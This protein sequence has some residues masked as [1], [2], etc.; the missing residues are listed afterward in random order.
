VRN[1]DGTLETV[2]LRFLEGV[3]SN[4]EDRMINEHIDAP[5]DSLVLLGHTQP[6]FPY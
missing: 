4:Y 6:P 5:D 1:R 2:S 3:H